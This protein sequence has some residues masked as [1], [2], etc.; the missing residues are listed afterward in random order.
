MPT[1]AELAYVNQVSRHYVR[2]YGFSP[3]FGRIAGWLLICD[4]PQQTASEIAE[5]LGM[6]RSA[7]G[8]A[9]SMLEK[10]SA[11][12]RTRLSGERADRISLEKAF[13]AESL[14]S[15]AE[16]GAMAALGRAG[17]AL[18]RDASLERRARLIEMT[19]FADFL[20]ER[21]PAIADEWRERVAEMRASGE[22]PDAP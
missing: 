8:S 5:A 17:L 14:D 16:Y 7:V 2:Q 22:L 13:A 3:A 10:A 4:P 12:E 1:E 18:L 9:I 6:S 15:P 21:L 11:I 20:L 19:A